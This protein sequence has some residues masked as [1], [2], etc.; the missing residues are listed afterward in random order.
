MGYYKS[1]MADMGLLDFQEDNYLETM[2]DW[3]NAAIKK[4][5]EI[6]EGNKK[7]AEQ[8]KKLLP[9]CGLCEEVATGSVQITESPKDEVG[10]RIPVC[11]EH[12]EKLEDDSIQNNE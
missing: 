2:Q 9:Q 5:R 11:S 4:I 7:L 6:D 8:M 3:G 1:E 12:R 10:H